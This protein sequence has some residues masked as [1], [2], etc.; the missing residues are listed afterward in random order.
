MRLFIF[1]LIFF[2]CQ[3]DNYAHNCI[4][5]LREFKDTIPDFNKLINNKIIEI[6]TRIQDGKDKLEYIEEEKKRYAS[7]QKET[8]KLNKQIEP[9]KSANNQE[10]S[11][12]NDFKL[13]LTEV[14][15]L[16]Y[17][18]IEDQLK[19]Q[20]NAQ[21]RIKKLDH[22]EYKISKKENLNI[23]RSLNVDV[24]DFSE[25]FQCDLEANQDGSVYATQ[26][27]NLLSY[28]DSKLERF[29]KDKEFLTIDARMLKSRKTYY[30]EMRLIFTS[31]QALK[32]Y[33]NMD[34]GNP[35]KLSF[36]NDEYIY[37]NSNATSNGQLEAKSGNTIYKIQCALNKEQIKKLKSKDLNNIT[38]IWD[39]GIETYDIYHIDAF[40]KLMACIRKKN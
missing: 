25:A 21:Q 36:L 28:T 23:P 10:L 11:R 1:L 9:L 17:Q 35:I 14:N 2:C 26:Y 8:R 27:I 40:Q 16:P 30:L 7:D 22:A 3:R 5:L 6:N 4:Q 18:S 24:Y 39:A 20:K 32:I 31:P 37:L 29:F 13:L 38:F 12:L 33:G 34:S 15:Q 19:F